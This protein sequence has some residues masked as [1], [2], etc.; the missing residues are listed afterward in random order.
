MRWV[1][2]IETVS[3]VEQ[4]GAKGQWRIGDA[5]TK[6]LKEN[7]LL[8]KKDSEI[9]KLAPIKN[10]V[11]LDCAEKL[12]EKGI[13]HKGKP[14][15][16]P[17]IRALFQTAYAFE[18]DERNPKY[19][20]DVHREAGTPLNLKNAIVALRKT[21]KPITET[22]VRAI[23]SHWAEEAATKRKKSN[24]EARTKKKAG[25]AKLAKASQR[26]LAATTEEEKTQAEQ[27][28]QEAKREIAEQTAII[29]AT[30]S[31][32]PF[33]ADLDVDTSDVSALERWAKY[34]A[35]TAHTSKMKQEAKK[36]LK[37]LERIANLLEDSEQQ[38][39]ADGCNDIIAI[40]EEINTLVKRP[41]RKL[42]AIQGG[43][44]A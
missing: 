3:E 28:R 30:G 40:L 10:S 25:K 23:H 24:T 21:E 19:S 13:E 5:V 38:T 42:A 31:P 37:G 12:R 41:A 32:P 43:K 34:L 36:M 14:Y 27:E 33:N 20:W 15:S 7:D 44:S 1:N 11:F 8:Q 2:T 16:A 39:I 6:D 35:I 18:R 29:V 17:Y 26:K 4:A 22:N 9:V